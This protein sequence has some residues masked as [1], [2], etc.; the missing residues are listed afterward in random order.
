MPVFYELVRARLDRDGVVA[1]A[2]VIDR[3]GSVPREVGAKMVV[4]PHGEI[5]GSVGGGCGEALVKRDALEV[6]RSGRPAITRVDLTEPITDESETNCGGI[7]DVFVERLALD[8]PP[9]GGGPTPRAL[10][11]RLA[12]ARAGRNPAV[13]A[14]VVGGDAAPAGARLLALGSGERLGPEAG[15]TASLEGPIAEALSTG[16]SRRLRLAGSPALDVF[17]EALPPAPDLVIVGAGHIAQPLAIIG[18]ALD[19][20]VTVI[21]D[22][23]DFASRARFPGA[24]RVIADDLAAAVARHPIGPGTYLVL[25]TRGHRLDAQVL[26]LVIHKP[27]DYIGMIGS[28]RRVGTVLDHLRRAG[29]P[30]A[31]LARLHAPIGLD[32]GAD[33]PAEI[34]VAIAA[35]IVNVRRGGRGVSLSAR[36]RRVGS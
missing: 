1:L 22:R 9:Q 16:R 20:E 36:L 35:E 30:E 3:R 27:A 7:M 33:T 13:V 8:E 29:I 2:T 31:A 17:I 6:I 10:L 25:V 5:A 18:K 14:T 34:A 12:R 32:I 19:F 24:D 11:D 26:R 23:A 15:W 28:R 21:D 4:S